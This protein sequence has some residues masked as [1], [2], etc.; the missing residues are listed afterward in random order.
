MEIVCLDLANVWTPPASDAPLRASHDMRDFE[1]LVPFHLARFLK[2]DPERITARALTYPAG[3]WEMEGILR[4]WIEHGTL[5]ELC[6]T[7]GWGELTLKDTIFRIDIR[8]I[9]NFDCPFG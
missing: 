6:S 8:R 2:I 3:T 4:I 5:T 7:R 9:P 1:F